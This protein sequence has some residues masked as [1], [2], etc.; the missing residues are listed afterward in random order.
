[1]AELKKFLFDNF[2]IEPQKKESFIQNDVFEAPQKDFVVET[3]AQTPVLETSVSAKELEEK[4]QK[5]ANDG[6][7]KGLLKAQ[8]TE[9]K[10]E[11]LLMQAISSNMQQLLK[12]EDNG[13]NQEYQKHVQNMGLLILE[14]LV[15]TLQKK[16]AFNII[17]E[18]LTQN[19]QNFKVEKKLSIH[20]NPQNINEVGKVIENLA[21]QH[22]F[23]GK[24]SIIKDTSISELDCKVL[25]NYGG[26]S[27]NQ[28]DNKK[29]IQEI[30]K[31]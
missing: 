15:P 23:E 17:E 6:Y 12:A 8:E 3:I 14:K 19:F 11:H 4:V 7:N 26:V 20:L 2:I 1:M 21:H 13:I 31:A 9:Q 16:E 24:I 30:I 29:A 5:A 22:D 28:E 10:Q 27:L 25:W 18:F